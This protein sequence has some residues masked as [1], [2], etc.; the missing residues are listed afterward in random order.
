MDWK[1]IL[2]DSGKKTI[3]RVAGIAGTDANAFE[4]LLELSLTDKSPMCN[5]A[6]RAMYLCL[7]KDIFLIEPHVGRIVRTLPD[8]KNESLRGNFIKMFTICNLPEDEDDL[9]GMINICF[10]FMNMSMKRIAAKVYCMEVLYRICE[11]LPELKGEL[12]WTIKNQMPY[13]TPGFI[14]RGRKIIKKLNYSPD[15]EYISEME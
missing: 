12:Y 4:Q 13:S 7:E 11:F 3:Y 2:N 1:K 9:G 6:A 8:L 15:D 5:R 14:S 10:D